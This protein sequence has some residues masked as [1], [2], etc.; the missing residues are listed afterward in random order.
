MKKKLSLALVVLMIATMFTVFTVGGSAEDGYTLVNGLLT[1]TKDLDGSTLEDYPWNDKRAE[2]TKVVVSDGVTKVGQRSFSKMEN[3]TEV[4]FGKDVKELGADAMSYN[5]KLETITFTAP[6]E[7]IGQGIVFSTMNIKTVNLYGQTKEQFVAIATATA[8]NFKSNGGM[9]TGFDTANFVV[10]GDVTDS[11]VKL[12]ITPKYGKI[13]NWSDKTWFIV[14]GTDGMV[15]NLRT[16][17]YGDAKTLNLKV[18][19]VDETESKT[20]VIPQYFFD[21]TTNEVYMDSKGQTFLRIAVC[22]YGIIP[23]KTHTYT[24]SLEFTDVVT[25]ATKFYGTS[26]KGAFSESTNAS[27]K[28]DGAIIPDTIPHPLPV[29]LTASFG[30]IENYGGKTLFIV[31]GL[32]KDVLTKMSD[33]TYVVKAVITDEIDKKTYTI[34]NYDFAG[35][36]ALEA[37]AGNSLFR[38]SACDYGIVPVDG[39][40]YTI[41]LEITEKETGKLVLTGASAEGAFDEGNEDFKAKG[42]II[43]ETVRGYYDEYEQTPPVDPN[44]PSTGDATVIIAAL[45]VVALFGTAVIVKKVHD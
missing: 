9:E 36:G 5:E 1:V 45:A 12:T 2:I 34:S 7:T 10:K 24:V 43:P 23:D 22:E 31:G 37:D 39:H 19:I 27:F 6:V 13:E 28:A 3:L 8:Y 38:L 32:S 40:K 4:T 21:N 29:D 25:G 15:E 18:T 33:G 16:A 20:Y 44:G 42:A 41:E 11:A 17:L 14:G 26:A 35:T 30:K